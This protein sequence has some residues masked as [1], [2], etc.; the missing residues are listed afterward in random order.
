V[1]KV[2]DARVATFILIQALSS[3]NDWYHADGRLALDELIKVYI[4]LAFSMLGASG[5]IT[6]RKTAPKPE[7]HLR[8]HRLGRLL[9]P[10]SSQTLAD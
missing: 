7:L 6:K 10:D 3:V 8:A 9:S 4:Q 1:F 2:P 5:A